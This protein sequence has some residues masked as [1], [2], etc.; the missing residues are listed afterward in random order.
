[1]QLVSQTHMVVYLALLHASH[2]SCISMHN[3]VM[4]HPVMWCV[5]VGTAKVQFKHMRLCIFLTAIFGLPCNFVY[6]PPQCRA[7]Y[8]AQPNTVHYGPNSE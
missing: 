8:H 4:S 6:L 7:C 3:F 5:A 1:M 2:R